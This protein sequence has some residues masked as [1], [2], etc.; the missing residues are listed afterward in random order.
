MANKACYSFKLPTHGNRNNR[1]NRLQLTPKPITITLT[2]HRIKT[3]QQ[4][5]PPID[6][7]YYARHYHTLCSTTGSPIAIITFCQAANAGRSRDRWV[8]TR[9][10]ERPECQRHYAGGRLGGRILENSLTVMQTSDGGVASQAPG[11]GEEWVLP[12][13]SP[14]S[15]NGFGWKCCRCAAVNFPAIDGL[16]LRPSSG[17]SVRRDGRIRRIFFL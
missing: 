16:R 4:K 2:E 1:L 13:P 15:V 8:R 12:T 6:H 11:H 5:Q 17:R 14:S 9:K 10:E 7:R 3:K